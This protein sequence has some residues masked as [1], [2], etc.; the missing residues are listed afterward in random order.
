MSDNTSVKSASAGSG[1]AAKHYFVRISLSYSFAQEKDRE[2]ILP[3]TV[4]RSRIPASFEPEGVW[5][6]YT[7]GV[8]RMTAEN[9]EACRAAVRTVW[10][11]VYPESPDAFRVLV[12]PDTEDDRAKL[13]RAVFTGYMGA[14]PYIELCTELRRTIEMLAEKDSLGAARAQSYLFSIDPGCGFTTLLSSFGDYMRRMGVFGEKS[15][16]RTKYIEYTL[17][18]ESENGCSTADDVLSGL[19]KNEDEINNAVIGL[20]ISYYLD[21]QKFDELRKFLKR[22]TRYSDLYVFVFRVPFLEKKSLSD[23]ESTIADQML[24]RTVEF[25]PLHDF[26]AREVFYDALHTA[27]YSAEPE[28]YDEFY[29]KVQEEKT[30]GRYYGFKTLEKVAASLILHKAAKDAKL[31]ADG[32]ASDR[33]HVLRE[34]LTGWV[35]DVSK[36]RT[37][38]DELS[39]LIGMETIRDRIREIVAQV[40]LSMADERLDRPCIHMRF[41]GAPGTGKTTVARIVGRIFKEEG[42]LRKGAFMEYTARNLCAE[43]V[44]QTAVKTAAICRDAYGS[45]LFI[46]EAYALYENQHESSNDYGKEALTTLIA[47]MENHRDDMLVIMAGYTDD[48]E[49]LMEGNAGLRSR[50]PY[51][52]T[53]ANYTR[54]QLHE[55]FMSMVSKHFDYTPELEEAS[56]TYFEELSEEYVQSREFSNARFVRNLYERTWSKAALRASL[57]GQQKVSLTKEDFLTASGEKEFREKLKQTVKVGF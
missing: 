19:A 52:L 18:K 21:G 4:I 45:V 28:L 7:F 11:E 8:I 14:D 35:K 22:L 25:P 44:G 5:T 10:N 53:F 34:D 26:V 9:E 46:D 51:V 16:A 37:G 31:E 6:R 29:R 3:V 48:M 30:D 43:Y 50:M 13:M 54:R 55:I 41:V 39:D 38:Y 12:T 47:E 33:E 1:N 40:K 49:T 27:G 56:R 20:D 32:K 23:I 15:D 24:V 36:K 42:I 17:G 57:D 2:G